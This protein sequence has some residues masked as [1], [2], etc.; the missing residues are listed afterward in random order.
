MAFK[1]RNNEIV[2]NSSIAE[3]D[4]LRL[5]NVEA[6]ATTSPEVLI[7]DG[8]GNVTLQNVTIDSSNIIEG[9]GDLIES[10]Q[11][12]LESWFT[13]SNHTYI[14][15]TYDDIANEMIFD[16][17]NA[18]TTSNAYTDTREVAITTAYESYT[19]QAETDANAYTDTRET[20]ITTAYQSYADAAETDANA[21]TD[22][23]E[24]AITTAYE[25][26]TDQAET[27]ANAYTDTEV[28]TEAGI[29]SVSDTNLQDQIDSITGGTTPII[30]TEKVCFDE[31]LVS[32]PVYHEGCL[33]YDETHKALSYYNDASDVTLNIGREFMVRVINNTGALITNGSAVYMSGTDI[34]VDVPEITLAQADA[35]ATTHVD[36][37]VTHDI[38]DGATGYVTRMGT[39]RDIAT[40]SYTAGDILYLSSTLAGALT[41][42]PPAWHGYVVEVGRVTKVD[43]SVGEVEVA[44]VSHSFLDLQVENLAHFESGIHVHGAINT[45][46]QLINNV[47]DP[48]SPQDAATRYYV[49]DIS[50]ALHAAAIAIAESYTDSQITTVANPYA[51]IAAL[52]AQ[53]TATAD[54]TTW[55]TSNYYNSTVTDTLLSSKL[56]ASDPA[57]GVQLN[58]V[59]LGRSTYVFLLYNFLVF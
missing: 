12:A 32:N 22:T 8:L 46:N 41:A 34:V 15:A 53:T 51:D 39:V 49:D 21:Y 9:T 54:V 3:V 28:A 16:A 7:H 27:D 35:I 4:S 10:L 48:V 19:D 11:D 50:S 17:T 45:G 24:V 40:S 59:V 5:G 52:N 38:P 18:V 2:F 13:H 33:F 6:G 31:A 25:S 14:V 37:L 23:R 20:A 55:V 26:Y 29:R 36:G 1:V 42:T 44:I 43:A 58:S 47:A 30:G 57:A 56:N